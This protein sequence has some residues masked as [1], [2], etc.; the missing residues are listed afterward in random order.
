MKNGDEISDRKKKWQRWTTVMSYS[1]II[2]II[3]VAAL[4]ITD[5]KSSLAL[6]IFLISTVVF[7]IGFASLLSLSAKEPWI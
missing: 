7:W 5:C 6:V 4:I 2:W 1:L 3:S